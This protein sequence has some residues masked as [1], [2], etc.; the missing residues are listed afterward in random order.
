MNKHFPKKHEF[1]TSYIDIQKFQSFSVKGIIKYRNKKIKGILNSISIKN[2][3]FLVKEQQ[4]SLKQIIQNLI[5]YERYFIYLAFLILRYN[6][7]IMFSLPQNNIY[8]KQIIITHRSLKSL[9]KEL[10]SLYTSTYYFFENL[11]LQE[12]KL[13]Q[14]IQNKPFSV[15]AI[16]YILCSKSINYS[17]ITK[18]KIIKKEK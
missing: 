1:D 7:K 14:S 6:T 17:Q 12:L 15:R 9:K 5:D 8:I 2:P 13:S 11:S 3:I 10:F 16:A 4:I 18:Q